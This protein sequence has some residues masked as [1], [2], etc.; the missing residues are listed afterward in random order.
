MKKI[1]LY[2]ALISISLLGALSCA[3]DSTEVNLEPENRAS[4]LTQTTAG[5]SLEGVVVRQFDKSSDQIITNET[6]T[7][8]SISNY[9]YTNYV[10]A[11]LSG[12]LALDSTVTIS[13]RAVG[14]DG[15]DSGNYVM[16]VIKVD[17]EE[18]CYWL[19]NSDSR[20]G[21]LLKFY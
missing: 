12:T 11:S 21:F 6:S 10:T 2:F 7:L 8:Y 13:Y 9:A 15:L 19:W 5:V 1:T 14:V 4:F 3:K 16:T 17:D 18:S 20:L